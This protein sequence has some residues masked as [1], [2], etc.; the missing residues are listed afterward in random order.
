MIKNIKFKSLLI[1]I[2]SLIIL[3]N[4]FN[5]VIAEQSNSIRLVVDGTDITDLSAPVIENDRTLVPVRFIAEALG[6]EVSWDGINRTV[7]IQK[8]S[9]TLFLK[10]G[11]Y[12]VEYNNGESY[13]LSD[14]PPKIINDR[15]YV[16][17][18]L[19][20]N[21][22]GIGISWDDATRT[23]N[24][25]SSQSSEIQSFFDLSIIS[26]TDGDTIT[27]D[28]VFS[29]SA[30]KEL[31][32]SAHEI[33]ILFLNQET[34]EGFIIARSTNLDTEFNYNAKPEDNGKK[35]LVAAL[36]D[37][38]GNFI[39]G[40]SISITIDIS[41][42]V[43][44]AGVSKYQI[45]KNTVELTPSLNFKAAYVNY[46]IK[47]SR[48]N[49]TKTIKEQDP[50]GSLS[51]TPV[52]EQNG[53]TTVKITAYDSNGITYESES[54]PV[55]VSV[56]R[57]LNLGGVSADSTIDKPVTLYAFRNYDVD[58]TQF[59][60]MDVQTGKTKVLGKLPYGGFEWFPGPED[61]GE[62]Y[63]LTR[64]QD[65]SGI[66]YQ[67]KPVKVTVDGSPKT[68]FTGIGPSQV[69]TSTTTLNI[70]SNVETID[71]RYILTIKST[72]AVRYLY[73]DSSAS[74]TVTFT[75]LSSD[76]GDCSIQAEITHQG[77]KILSQKIDFTIYHGKTYGPEAITSKDGFL[78]FASSLA[79]ESM[80]KTG[81]SAALQTAQAI[82]E[83]GWGQSVPV[84][85]YNGTFSNNL[86]GIKGT[87][88][89]GSVISNTW[90]VFNGKSYRVDDYFRAYVTV[91]D[92]WDDH[93]GFLLALSR[94]EIFRTV[95]HNSADGAWALKRAGYATDP[96]YAI[97]LIKIINTYNLN[98]LDKTSL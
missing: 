3:L 19:V 40:D 97:K 23:V 33:K 39:G 53:I 68:L 86:F 74:D 10:I 49:Y 37:S 84:D 91:S 1:F 61:S 58:E 67:S 95:M 35:I 82:L 34:F 15:T 69:I 24:I 22:F 13:N 41:P 83:T 80:S 48:N 88:N 4:S 78:D 62:K 32:S 85:K 38:K 73:P 31:M 42:T 27:Q 70:K 26:H 52:L 77:Q 47:N 81:M 45:V 30:G 8:G 17:A 12:I 50:E 6:A 9:E 20:S 21:A 72:G 71:I 18:R 75:P 44:V 60:L 66:Y 54:M 16:P 46:E 43:S 5:Y 94:Y 98:E 2:L 64:V 76:E 25:D 79:V 36:Y 59:L 93:K 96:K 7:T 89:N 55:I 57:E 14:V 90:E 56:K 28:T 11:S 65:T 51:W 87:G 92:G 29:V 63:L